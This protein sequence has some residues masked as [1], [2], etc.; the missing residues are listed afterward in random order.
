MEAHA[1]EVQRKLQAG[2]AGFR[3]LRTASDQFRPLP[4][5]SDHFRPPPT[6]SKRLRL[7]LTYRCILRLGAR[8]QGRACPPEARQRE[9]RLGQAD[10]KARVS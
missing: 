2:W 5:A 6:A 10:S 8:L 1:M 4:A 9:G 3:P 7:Y